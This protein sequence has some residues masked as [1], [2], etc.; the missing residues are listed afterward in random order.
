MMR[1][2]Y[3]V[4]GI[5]RDA[6]EDA[7]KK[8][9]RKLA[10]QH[11]PD[12]NG[13]SEE[14]A[15]KF[16]EVS[17]AYEQLTNPDAQQDPEMGGFDF[18]FGNGMFSDIFNNIFGGGQ[19]TGGRNVQA[20][21]VLTFEE[22]CFGCVKEVR[23]SGEE[24]C[25]ACVGIGATAG[26]Y[27]VCPAC[28]GSGQNVMQRGPIV[29]SGGICRSCNG[30]KHT[31]TKPCDACRG[32]GAMKASKVH[33]VQIPSCIS[34]G[35]TLQ[36]PGAGL[37]GLNG[38]VGH[39]LV[40]VGIHRHPDFTR[41]GLDV[42]STCSVS[43]KEALL[44]CEKEVS[45]IHKPTLVKIP[46]LTKPGQNL[47]LKDLGAKHPNNGSFGKHILNIQVEFPT[48]LTDDQKDTLGKIL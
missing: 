21:V 26:N 9:Y 14:S 32:T 39:L 27:T 16:K 17:Q 19:Q 10:M 48:S 47:S 29:I 40:R 45:T 30:K 36:V 44:G 31:I 35:A 20:S 3:E 2:P 11:H 23:V 8:A 15:E 28:K 33:K 42:L 12:R 41:E 18:D 34:N 37:A 4:L 1:D 43:L 24:A 13:G 46:P 38:D 7:I 5:P 6:D 25:G 22:S